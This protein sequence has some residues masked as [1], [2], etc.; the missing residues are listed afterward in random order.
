M[1][2][3]YILGT[4]NLINKS[5]LNLTCPYGDFKANNPRYKVS[6]DSKKKG[7]NLD[8]DQTT[9]PVDPDDP[10]RSEVCI[11]M[12]IYILHHS[13][14]STQSQHAKENKDSKRNSPL[15]HYA[16]TNKSISKKE[17]G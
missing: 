9:N 7:I 4:R 1:N 11:A 12:Y 10:L 5:W 2:Q 3:S 17:T 15:V 8:L 6:M 16:R 13:N 14:Q